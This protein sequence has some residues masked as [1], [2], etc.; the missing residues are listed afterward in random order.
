MIV[1]D[2]ARRFGVA[3]GFEEMNLLTEHS[4]KI[5]LT[6]KAKTSLDRKSVV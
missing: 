3:E 5:W 4:R 6:W 1:G 2:G